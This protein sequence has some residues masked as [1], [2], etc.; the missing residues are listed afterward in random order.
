[1][2]TQVWNPCAPLQLYTVGS[3][4]PGVEPRA[5]LQLYTAGSDYQGVEPLYPQFAALP[6]VPL[7]QPKIGIILSFP[8]IY[9]HYHQ[10]PRYHWCNL[11]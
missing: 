1:M 6:E 7:V 11:K 3:D 8:Q 10:L 4:H 2:I 5:P 9:H